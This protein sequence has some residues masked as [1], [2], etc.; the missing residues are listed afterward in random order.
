ISK[1]ESQLSFEGNQDIHEAAI[2]RDEGQD[3]SSP[4]AGICSTNQPGILKHKGVD[5]VMVR[6]KDRK[7]CVL[8]IKSNKPHD[9]DRGDDNGKPDNK[10]NTVKA[11]KLV[12]NLGA[13]K[14]NN[15][16]SPISDASS[17]QKEQDAILCN[18]VQD[19]NQQRVDYKFMLDRSDNTAKSGIKVYH[20]KSRGVKIA[21]REGNVIKFGKIRSEFPEL[22]SKVGEAKGSDG[23]EI[24]PLEQAHVASGEGINII[25]LD[26]AVPSDEVSILGGNVKSGKRSEERADTYDESNEDY[27]HTPVLNSLP[28]DPKPSLKF[29]LKKPN[30]VNQNSN[31]HSEEEKSSIKGQ[32]SK[33]QKPSSFVEKSL[34]NV[35]EDFDVTQTHQNSIMDGLMDASWILK[36]LGKDAIGKKVEIYQA[37]DKSWHKGAVNDIIEG[38]SSVSVMLDDG[39]VK[40][41]ELGKQGIRFVLQKQKRQKF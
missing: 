37:S 39:R 27:G 15:T 6:D 25:R 3:I 20:S 13:R 38:T 33:R 9:L 1:G 28:K 32:R 18:G 7:S 26:A 36:K 31:A 10:S 40:S 16:N 41:L 8:K 19:A 30:L 2:Q 5:E 22:G 14:I 12:I 4:V 29:K 11:K 23:Y 24:D 34:F 35:D 21:G 17:S